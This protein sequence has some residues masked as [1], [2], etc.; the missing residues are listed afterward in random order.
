[1]KQALLI[2]HFKCK[3]LKYLFTKVVSLAVNSASTS[4]LYCGQDF[5]DMQYTQVHKLHISKQLQ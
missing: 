4:A 1:M 5:L 3:S 2:K